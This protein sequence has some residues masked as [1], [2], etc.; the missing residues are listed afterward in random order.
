MRAGVHL[1]AMLLGSAGL[2]GSLALGQPPEQG[3]TPRPGLTARQTKQAVELAHGAMQE[4][5][6][7]TEGAT[8]P[9]ADRREYVVN[10]ELL[11][12]QENEATARKDA[13]KQILSR[14]PRRST[15][16]PQAP[17]PS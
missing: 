16:V 12:A 3:S 1:V 2:A 9:E 7:K 5:R 13:A 17:A 10:V 4:L 15:Q 6:K 11:S 8:E 14:S